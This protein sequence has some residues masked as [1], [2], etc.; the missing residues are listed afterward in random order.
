MKRS[1]FLSSVALIAA[2]FLVVV[3]AHP[4]FAHEK[5]HVGKYTFVVGFLNEPAY[6]QQSNSL[7][8]TV[9]LGNACTYK[10]QDGSRIVANPVNNLE[11][12][13]KVEV[14]TG[15]HA[16]IPLTV[17]PRYANPGKYN[18]YFEPTTTGNYTF[19][20]YGT[21][22]SDKVDE[23]FT[24]SPNGFSAVAAINAYPATT[25]NAE[26]ANT[27]AL[28]NQVTSAQ[29][30]ASQALTIG[31]IGAVLGVL[32]IIVAGVALLRRTTVKTG[33]AQQEPVERLQG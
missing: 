19:H 20:I 9:C 28:K 14:S 25:Q 24:S 22:N 17:S 31:G 26:P 18:A 11:Q 4:A 6:A 1:V 2:L 16:P 15:A 7:D 5:R 30:A 32:G 21:V 13:L 33:E 8:L 27:D 3:V 12:S 23:K 10:V 29:N